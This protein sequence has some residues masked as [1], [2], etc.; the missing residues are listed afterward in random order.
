MQVSEGVLCSHTLH[1]SSPRIEPSDLLPACV[2]QFWKPVIQLCVT[3]HSL[4]SLVIDRILTFVTDH[5]QLPSSEHSIIDRQRIGW[6]FYLIDQAAATID[7]RTIF[8]RL[9]RILQPWFAEPL[10]QLVVRMADD[11]GGIQQTLISEQKR[12]TM[13]RTISMFANP[14]ENVQSEPSTRI[15]PLEI[16]PRNELNRTAMNMFK[17]R[18]TDGWSGLSRTDTSLAFQV[19]P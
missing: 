9:V 6:V 7:L 19:S 13:L 10:S 11:M 18:K 15:S 5:Y 14:F 2:I 16:I 12:D 4:V 3:D 8:L 1:T 17:K